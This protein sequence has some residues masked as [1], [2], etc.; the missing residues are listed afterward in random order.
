M[1]Q[2]MLGLSQC[3]LQHPVLNEKLQYKIKYL[4]VLQYFTDLYSKENEFAQSM[5]K[6][7][8]Q[9]FLQ[10]VSCYTYSEKEIKKVFKKATQFKLKGF[11]LF[12]YRYNLLF[13][14]F[15]INAFNDEKKARE[16]TTAIGSLFSPRYFKRIEALFEMLYCGVKTE[17]VG[18]ETQIS[19]WNE[20]KDFFDKPLKRILITANMSAG[21]STLINALIGKKI[22]KTKN[23]ACTAKIH[24]IYNKPF[25][26][27]L[28]YE[29]DYNLELDADKKTLMD[30]N[31]LNT[32][33][34]ICVGAYFR[35]ISTI[36]NR[37]CLIDTPGVNSF[38]NTSHKD[39][40][41]KIITESRYDMLVYVMNAENSGT[42][43]DRKHLNFVLE[44]V[45]NKPIVFVINKLDTFSKDEDNI[46]EIILDAEKELLEMGFEN[47]IICPLSAY[48][49]ILAKKMLWNEFDDEDE[50]IEYAINRKRFSDDEYDLSKYGDDVMVKS[51]SD[52]KK[53]QAIE[54]LKKAGFINFENILCK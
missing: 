43:D 31:V 4:N 38:E 51:F 30:D 9:R 27:N 14:C 2:E 49:A 20:N 3:L 42:F 25:E 46:N 54:L 12:T 6:I 32:T 29:W 15:F 36:N 13:D 44:N 19:C 22:N 50:Q 33:S 39:V 40:T 35:L 11:K 17:F 52:N 41:E 16:I 5:L 34:D 23:E 45:K 48:A 28:A 18:L 21:K 24:Y 47:P 1:Q 37:I 10:D 8:K 26:D 7:Y 53:D